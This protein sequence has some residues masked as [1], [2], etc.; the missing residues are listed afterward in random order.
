MSNDQNSDFYALLKKLGFQLE[1]QM[2]Q[3]IQDGLNKEEIIKIA[4]I[5]GQVLGRLLEG[6][7]DFI[8]HASIPMNFPTKNDVSRVGKLVVQSE[9]KLDLIEEQVF[10]ILSLLK[11]NAV[12]EGIAQALDKRRDKVF[13]GAEVKENRTNAV[14]NDLKQKLIDSANG[15][16][17][18]GTEDPFSE[19]LI[20]RVLEKRGIKS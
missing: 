19:V 11:G 20:K 5:G 4:N 10:E 9:D 1:G 3:F 14:R 18:N 12:S 6:L 17:K 16:G 2:N 15:L 8:E 13:K 7:Q